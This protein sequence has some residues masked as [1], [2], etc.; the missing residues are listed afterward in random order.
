MKII[1]TNQAL[2]DFCTTAAQSSFVC[3]DTEFMRE[4][5]FY[6]ILCLIQAAT[7]TDEVIID[8]M[9][10]DLD[11]TP[12]LELMKDQSLV[13]VMHAARQDLEIFYHIMGTVPAPVFDTQIAAMALGFGESVGYQSLVKGRLNRNLDKGARFTDWSKRPLS[14][15]QCRYALADVTH[16]RDLYPGMVDELQERGRLT[17]LEEEMQAQLDPELYRD[18]PEKAWERLKLRS[19][20]REY[21]AALKAVAA[22]RERKAIDRNIPRRR[23]MKDDVLYNIAQQRPRTLK[24]LINMRGIPKGFERSDTA[25]LLINDLNYALDNLDSYAPPKPKVQHMPPNQGP[26]IEMLRTLLRIRTE[27]VDIAPR[28]V[29]SNRDIEQ[30]A[31]F[32]ERADVPALTGWRRAVF[33]ED[34]LKMI[35]GELALRLQNREVVV[36]PLSA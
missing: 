24:G 7:D 35:R 31:A 19:H 5:T 3:V 4:S 15:K 34:A 26:T 10:D 33:G 32:G 6:S 12:F 9:A 17:W 25:Q 27:Y 21:L 20:K 8:P 28:L 2:Q 13:K 29:A 14:E 11:L 36:E 22:W 30:I 16:L 18:N 1:T 23:I